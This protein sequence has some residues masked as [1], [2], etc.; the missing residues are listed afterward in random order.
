MVMGVGKMT[1]FFRFAC[2]LVEI[3]V[4]S[5]IIVREGSLVASSRRGEGGHLIRKELRGSNG[6]DW[7]E[8]KGRPTVD[9]CLFACLLACWIAR[10]LDCWIA[11]LL[12]VCL[13]AC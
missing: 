10:L 2:P 11:G 9:S 6:M 4:I 12:L 7:R 5:T 13:F 3:E 1:F 8:E